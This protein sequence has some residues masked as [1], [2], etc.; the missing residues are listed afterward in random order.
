MKEEFILSD[1]TLR[2][3]F[4]EKSLRQALVNLYLR[5]QGLSYPLLPETADLVPL[6]LACP[7]GKDFHLT[8]VGTSLGYNLLE[9]RNQVEE[10]RSNNILER[11]KIDQNSVLFD[12]GC[13]GGQTL[14]A[15][16][17]FNPQKVVGFDRDGYA[18]ALARFLFSQKKVPPERYS[19]F[20]ASLEPTGN[21]PP[22]LNPLPQRGEG[23][24]RV[25]FTHIVC[26]VVL[27]KLKVRQTLSLFYHTLKPAGSLYLMV[28]SFSY[29]VSRLNLV[30]RNPLWS[31]YFLFV[32]VNGFV[33]A[34]FGWQMTLRLGSRTLSELFFTRRS[35][36]RALQHNHFQTTEILFPSVPGKSSFL[37][38]FARKC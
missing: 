2:R 3:I 8:P 27:H 35:L 34:F 7:R 23:R 13:G 32:F 19:F 12:V 21:Y 31:V 37:E 9:Y 28:P 10:G 4:Q 17:Q 15:S 20:H 29:Y 5:Q 16:L 1:D 33:F 26:R 11:M 14:L 36:K 6:H 24:V 38:V 30:F 22:H 25:E 18:I